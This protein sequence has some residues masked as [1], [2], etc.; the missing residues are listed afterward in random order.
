MESLREGRALNGFLIVWA[1]QNP[2]PLRE[3]AFG[4]NRFEQVKTCQNRGIFVFS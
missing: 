2:N 1:K 4:I 3:I